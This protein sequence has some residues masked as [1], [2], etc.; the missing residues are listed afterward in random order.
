MF[1]VYTISMVG[2]GGT[3]FIE[4]LVRSF[5]SNEYAVLLGFA[6]VFG[7]LELVLTL[8]LRYYS[9]YHL[10]HKFNLSNQRLLSWLREG[11]KGMLVG[12]AIG[13]PLLLIFFYCLRS[14]QELWWIP[15]GIVMFL[16]SVIIA[17]LAPVLIFP[18][19]YEFKP[20]GDGSLKSRLVAL[21]ER[22]GVKVEKVYVFDMS[23]NTKKANAAF[24]GIGKTKRILLGDTLVA[25]CSD[26]EIE[27]VVAHELGHNK[28]N[29]LWRMILLGTVTTFA[30]LWLTALLYSESVA[31]FGLS[32]I[33][34]PAALPL[35]SV[36]F[37]LYSILIG[38]MTNG[39]SR[40]HEYAADR[41]AVQSTRNKEAFLNALRKLSII[42]LS[43]P[44]PHP[45]V[46]LWAYSHP[47]LPKRIKAIAALS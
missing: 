16:F 47:P 43:D 34:Q 11:S 23:K 26:E 42:N 21:C 24:T 28:M 45:L 31:W 46:E 15:V 38:P 17:R 27:T 5:L 44:E 9:G 3:L 12:L 22:G 10:E 37:G 6:A 33:G 8:P 35:L 2:L 13:T 25:N 4:D 39:V 41:F 18:L 19:F 30:G 20:L 32:S 1:F 7:A 14:Y 40:G 29:H 36:W